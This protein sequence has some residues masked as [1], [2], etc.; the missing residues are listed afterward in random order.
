[1][2]LH[3]LPPAFGQ[4]NPSPFCLKA[5]MALSFLDLEFT[6]RPSLELNKAPKGKMPW[7]EDGDTVIADSE[8]ILNHLDQKTGGK[9]YAELTPLERAKGTAFLRLAEDH[10]YWMIVASRW[11][12]DE[13]FETVKRDFFGTLP[14]PVGWLASTM[15]RRTMRQTYKLHGLG[16]HSHAEQV[17][18]LRTDLQAMADQVA[19]EGYIAGIRMTA[20]DFGVGAMLAAG[21]DNQPATWV[22]TI[23]NEYEDLR[24]YIEKVQSE[25]GVYCR[26]QA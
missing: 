14:A 8:L 15:A 6:N 26:E 7:L 12:D 22:S 19:T 4:R 17:T 2:I 25:T 11:L 20:Y 1:M 10:L 23:A 21:M 5:E 18:L 24:N 13:W 3:T 9:L 16:R